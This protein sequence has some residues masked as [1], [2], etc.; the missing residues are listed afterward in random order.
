VNQI[1]RPCS[2]CV[3]ALS[4]GLG[5]G[6][7]DPSTSIAYR[8]SDGA[9]ATGGNATAGHSGTGEPGS[10]AGG[11]EATGGSATAGRS[12]TGGNGSTA[13]GAPATGG[14]ATTGGS[15]S[16]GNGSGTGGAAATGGNATTGG[17]SSGGN[18]S[19]TGGA[20]AA[21]GSETIEPLLPLS[22]GNTWTYQVTTDAGVT[23]KVHTIGELEEVGGEGPNA[24]LMAHRV[25]SDKGGDQT[26][27]WQ[28]T[29]GDRVVRYREQ[30]FHRTTGELELEEHWEPYKLRIDWSAEHLREGVSWVEEYAETKLPDAAVRVTT[31]VSDT[32]T[33]VSLSERVSVPAGE[34]DAIVFTKVGATS[35]KVYWYVP[36]LGKVKE[37]GGQVEELQSYTVAP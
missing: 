34:F 20:P 23:I 24:S 12:G 19:S 37:T 4:L 8:A 3:L 16:G 6:T 11:A 5:C 35:A 13:G 33:V 25:T 30:A 7:Q 17:S 29:D 27:S 22:P 36:G 31:S 28:A 21:E 18:G 14:S 9:G 26:I 32:W 10:T 15:S 1:D 2:V